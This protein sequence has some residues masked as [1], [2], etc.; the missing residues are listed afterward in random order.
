MDYDELTR[1]DL[2]GGTQINLY[3][4]LGSSTSEI[5][6]KRLLDDRSVSR[7]I[8]TSQRISAVEGFETCQSIKQ[9]QKLETHDQLVE[10]QD[11]HA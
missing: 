11:A 5:C 1:D 9:P 6:I 4:V 2:I 3:E 7:E 8:S 10:A